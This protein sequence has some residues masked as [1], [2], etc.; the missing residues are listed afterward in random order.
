MKASV[1]VDGTGWHLRHVGG[2]RRMSQFEGS[3]LMDARI[4][5]RE[6]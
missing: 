2:T 4:T 3:G 6:S 1:T 5:E